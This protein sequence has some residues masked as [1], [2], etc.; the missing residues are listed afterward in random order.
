MLARN[1]RVILRNGVEVETP[2]LVPSLSSMAMPQVPSLSQDGSHTEDVA[3]SIVHSRLLLNGWDDTVLLSAYDIYHDLLADAATL[4]DNFD[5][6]PYSSTQLL[7]IDSGW[8]EKKANATGISYSN[9]GSPFRWT[10]EMYQETID[11]LDSRIDALVVCWDEPNPDSYESQ[12][13]AGQDFFGSRPELAATLLLKPIGELRTHNFGTLS[14]DVISNLRVFDMVGVTDNE[15]GDTLLDRLV[16]LATLRSLLDEKDVSAPIHVFGGLDPL[17]TPLLYAA[18]GEVFDGLGWIRYVYK[19]DMTIHRNAA[20]V[21]NRQVEQKWMAAL[22]DAQVL[23][24]QALRMLRDDLIV[25]RYN[26]GD[27]SRFNNG[28]DQLKPIFDRFE[29]AFGGTHGR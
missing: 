13:A 21:L 15:L 23:N 24:L 16:N 28:D 3:C 17:Y 19:H 22:T 7:V 26:Q 20:P 12:I 27:W 25:F 10:F 11:S 1:R 14:P 5:Q 9:K 2:L 4:Q 6:S 29:A 18:G 8:Y